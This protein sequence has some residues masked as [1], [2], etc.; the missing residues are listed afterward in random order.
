M[1][2][3]IEKAPAVP[4]AQEEPQPVLFRSKFKKFM[5]SIRLANGKE[6]I[7]EFANHHFEANPNRTDYPDVVKG[8]R[9]QIERN[10]GSQ[11]Q[12]MF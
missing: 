6:R 8:L 9:A 12:V 7:I 11:N 10:R 3:E 1:A 4:V 5:T 2:K